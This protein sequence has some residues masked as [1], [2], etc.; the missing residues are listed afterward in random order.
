MAFLNLHKETNE[1]GFKNCLP[2]ANTGDIEWL[3]VWKVVIKLH[4]A[5]V[6]GRHQEEFGQNDDES[7]NEDKNETLSNIETIP[8][9]TAFC[10]YF[11]KFVDN[12]KI[13][14]TSEVKYLKQNFN[15]CVI[16]LLEIVLMNDFG[17]EIG[18]NRLQGLLKKIL[19][20]YDVSEHVIEKISQVIELLITKPDARLTF[21]NEIVNEMVNLE[22]HEY[23]RKAIIDE[24]ISSCDNDVRL[25]AN[26]IK[27]QMMTLKEQETKF[28]EVKQYAKAQIVSEDYLKKNE[29][30]IELLKPYAQTRNDTSLESLSSM[31][32]SKKVTPAEILKN[33]RI[34]YY[35]VVSKGVKALIPE[36]VKIYNSFIRYHL[37]SKDIVTRIWAMKTATAYS[38]L[39]ETFAKDVYVI[40][41]SQFC[42]SNRPLIWRTAI[43]CIVDILLRYSLEKMDKPFQDDA[44]IQDGSMTNQSR[45]KRGGRSLYTDEGEDNEEMNLVVDVDIVQVLT[46]VLENNVDIKV[47]KATIIGLC[48]LLLHGQFYT[49]E[50]VSRFL[51]MYFNPAT[52]AELNQ[53]LGIF[54]ESVVKMK[55]QESLHDA[56]FPT[57]ATLLEAPC[58]SPLREVK[59]ETIVKYVIGATRPVFCS[60]GLNLHNTLALKLIETMKNNPENKEV[61]RVFTRE[62]LTLEISEDPLLKKDIVDQIENLLKIISVDVRTK[63]NITDF[64]DIINGTYRKALS[65]SS[66]AKASVDP[67]NEDAGEED[68]GDD[69]EQSNDVENASRLDAI[70]EATESEETAAD[71][72]ASGAAKTADTSANESQIKSPATLAPATQEEDEVPVTQDEAENVSLPATQDEASSESDAT[73]VS[74]D[75]EMNET[76]V[77]SVVVEDDVESLPP[78]PEGPKTPKTRKSATFKRQLELTATS[79]NSPMRKNPR[80]TA[81]PKVAHSSPKTPAP[82]RVSEAHVSPKTPNTRK[83]AAEAAKTPKAPATRRNTVA[84]ATPKT[85]ATRRNTI[86]EAGTPK[87]PVVM[88]EVEVHVSPVTPQTPRM[89]AA[90]NSSTPKSMTRKQVREEIAQNSTLTRSASRKMK[91]DP[92]EVAE[93]VAVRA[94]VQKAQS[95]SEPKV[96]KKSA[97]PVPTKTS[98]I[99]ASRVADNKKSESSKPTTSS[100][101]G[102]PPR[103]AAAQ[104][105]KAAIAAVVAGTRR[106][107][108]T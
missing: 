19:I 5:H 41:K 101:E 63:K 17:D 97:I 102:R 26:R 104:G 75:A 80:N 58:D 25:E 3:I 23:S 38:L 95:K 65:F 86:A 99:R 79:R 70:D 40:L 55:K 94:V 59:M 45:M 24:L 35:A 13:P 85:P 56:L 29:E 34:C 53:T 108:W 21:Y 6:E 107:R 47:Q 15:H 62:L 84:G 20:E 105:G 98:L 2:L 71:A 54:F 78:T 4:Q 44:S 89:A 69:L 103:R 22:T 10:D 67:E 76:V 27:H 66:T 52:E 68:E 88:Q 51:I 37:E 96:V 77:E 18:R 8:E 16:V 72:E 83:K 11:E 7:D 50:M 92:K 36:N 32:A 30:L 49:R 91:V 28:V 57:L 12:F 106:P 90:R 43:S 64:R 81:T 87:T 93:K 74:S 61:L 1:N 42:S 33:L 73:E 31:A 14:D 100:S 39:Y 82:R 9:L 46:H 48:K 60:T